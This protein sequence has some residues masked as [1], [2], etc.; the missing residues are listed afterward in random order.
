LPEQNRRL[1]H[2]Q[3]TKVP[4]N[5]VAGGQGNN[6]WHRMETIDQEL[7]EFL[8]GKIGKS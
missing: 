7:S 6:I 4:A 2:L 8:R 1:R 3:W 5:A